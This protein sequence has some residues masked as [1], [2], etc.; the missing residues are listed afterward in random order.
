[1][2]N[3][4]VTKKQARSFL[5]R[6]HGLTNEGAFKGEE[7]ILSYIRKVG[8]IQYDP[9]NV[10]GR[11][12]DLVMQSRI[13]NYSP[14]ML[15]KLLYEDRKLIDGWDKMM[16][17]YAVEDWAS[18]R[19]IREAHSRS[20]IHTMN[21]RGTTDALDMLA[22]VKNIIIEEGP[23]FAREIKLGDS[24]KGRWASGKQSSVA[25]DHMF[26][27][28]ELGVLTKKNAQKVFD[29]IENILPPHILNMSDPFENDEEFHKWYIE[30]RIK[31]V[32]MLWARNGGGWLGH[33]LSDKKLRSGL[34]EQMA[35]EGTLSK[36][37]VEGIKDEFY[38][39]SQDLKDLQ[40]D[41]SLEEGHMRILAPLD[42]MLW[43][44][45]M[46]E[47]IFDFKYSW[48]VYV[49]KEKRKYGYYVL[50]VLYGDSIIARFE[51]EKYKDGEPLK[52]I[53]WWWEEGITVTDEM[54]DKVSLSLQSFADYLGA[55]EVD[56]DVL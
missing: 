9:L 13:N 24:K 5:V 47:R 41:L 46:V 45:D 53:N 35:E 4:T 52:I 56:F 25:L 8:C 3:I 11:N 7:G 51:P 31:S 39:A 42:N 21:Y 26:H 6:Y 55:D 54:K 44:R 2:N 12:A 22:E 49:P 16:A 20:N 18:F 36:V 34:L 27:T 48:E 33:F 32:G 1:M 10:V 40:M 50:P 30:R 37:H 28:G 38:I 15:E 23:K 19:R 17:I 43:D 14:K 29:V